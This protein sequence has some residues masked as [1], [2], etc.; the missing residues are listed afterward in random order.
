MTTDNIMQRFFS[1]IKYNAKEDINKNYL[2]HQLAYH[3]FSFDASN[4]T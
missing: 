2:Y 1:N 3:Y 4:D